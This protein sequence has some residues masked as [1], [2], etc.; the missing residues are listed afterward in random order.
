MY[1][2]KLIPSKAKYAEKKSLTE[3]KISIKKIENNNKSKNSFKIL[4][5]RVYIVFFAISRL[6]KLRSKMNALKKIE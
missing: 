5:W 4:C 3:N 6:I 2:E 1:S